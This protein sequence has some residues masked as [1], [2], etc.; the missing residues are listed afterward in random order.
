MLAATIPALSWLLLVVRVEPHEVGSFPYGLTL[1]LTRVTLALKCWV[2]HNDS[3]MLIRCAITLLVIT[4]HHN[5]PAISDT[6]HILPYS[7]LRWRY[8]HLRL[9]TRRRGVGMGSDGMSYTT[10]PGHVI[11]RSQLKAAMWAASTPPALHTHTLERRVHS[12]VALC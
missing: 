4:V 2:V 8:S 9:S 3:L 6:E 5:P 1:G 11:T 7:H 12:C 10:Y